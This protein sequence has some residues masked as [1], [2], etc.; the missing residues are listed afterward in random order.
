[1]LETACKEIKES[2]Y[3]FLMIY[4]DHKK[5]E[6]TYNFYESHFVK[7]FN[8]LLTNIVNDV[9]SEHEVDLE[10]LEKS[11]G[12]I[13]NRGENIFC[14]TTIGNNVSKFILNYVVR[15]TEGL[16]E[17][18]LVKLPLILKESE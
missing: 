11:D 8:A 16:K 14:D 6:I 5:F 3:F 12:I 9:K 7:K 13:F 18:Y 4:V 1:M 2:I 10:E 17:F 15:E